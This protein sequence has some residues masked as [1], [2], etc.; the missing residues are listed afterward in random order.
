MNSFYVDNCVTSVNCVT[1]L[2]NFIC[3]SKASME[4]GQFDLR[5]W[6]FTHDDSYEKQTGV[7]GILWD[8]C[9]DTLSLNMDFAEKLDFDKVTKRKILSAAHRVYDP[10]GFVSPAVLCPRLLLQEAWAQKVSWDEEVNVDIKTRFNKWA[11]NLQELNKVKIPR[12][13]LGEI[14]ESDVVSLHTFV[15][16]SQVAYAAVIFLRVES[17][18]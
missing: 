8:K 11:D 5:G 10:L 15:D 17:E 2:S 6:E 13:F 18:A 1:E 4:L 3:D 12:C 7:L 16:A 9:D 14:N